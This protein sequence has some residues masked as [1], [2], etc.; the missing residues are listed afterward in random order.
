MWS[1]V[2][3]C[4]AMWSYVKLCEVDVWWFLWIWMNMMRQ[5]QFIVHLYE[6]LSCHR[7]LP[8]W[9]GPQWFPVTAT[10]SWDFAWFCHTL[11][12]YFNNSK[13]IQKYFAVFVQ[14]V[15]PLQHSVAWSTRIPL[16]WCPDAL[17]PRSLVKAKTGQ[18][19]PKLTDFCPRPSTWRWDWLMRCKLRW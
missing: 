14:Q 2:K 17:W 19:M 13:N 7:S 3:L 6:L 18:D 9:H 12:L 11:T 16:P 8:K 1:Y 4:E 15:L 10:L 5:R